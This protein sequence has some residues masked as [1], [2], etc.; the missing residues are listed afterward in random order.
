MLFPLSRFPRK[1]IE[2]QCN[3]C[4]RCRDN[5][6][7]ECVRVNYTIPVLLADPGPYDHPK[8]PCNYFFTSQHVSV[9]CT[10]ALKSKPVV[11]PSSVE[12]STKVGVASVE[13]SKSPPGR[14]ENSKSGQ[15]SV[16]EESPEIIENI[17]REA[18]NLKDGQ[19]NKQVTPKRKNN[20]KA[21]RKKAKEDKAVRGKKNKKHRKRKG[22]GKKSIKNI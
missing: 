18:V 13:N 15:S 12:I 3:P 19:N 17:D 2:A 8:T 20:A 16:S 5:E 9:G 11:P 6:H 21:G 14:K 1:L 10:C 7:T 22:K 4:G